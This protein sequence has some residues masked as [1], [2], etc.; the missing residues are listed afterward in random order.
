MRWTTR[1][2][3]S[4][5]HRL[6]ALVRLRQP[7]LLAR[8]IRRR[9]DDARDIDAEAA[10]RLDVDDADESGADDGCPDPA[11]PWANLTRMRGSL[12]S[13]R[14]LSGKVA[15]VTGAGGGIGGAVAQAFAGAGAEVIGSTAIRL[16]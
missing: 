12:H 2:R 5:E 8:S 3:S 7:G 13:G 4:A 16:I 1:T 15:V 9:A 14:A 6:E 10:Q 11:H